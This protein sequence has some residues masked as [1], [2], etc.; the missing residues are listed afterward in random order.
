VEHRPR[1]EPAAR[2]RGTTGNSGIIWE[3]A[4]TISFRDPYHQIGSAGWGCRG[5]LAMGAH[6]FCI[7]SR[8]V[9]GMAFNQ[10]T[11]GDVVTADGWQ[12]CGFYED[13]KSFAQVLTHEIGHT[14]GFDHS[15]DAS[16]IMYAT[17]H[18]DGRCAALAGS[19]K[20]GVVFAYPAGGLGAP[21]TFTISVVRAGSG[22]G[23]VTSTPA[24]ITCGTDCSQAYE[25]GT[26]VTLKATVPAGSRFAG[27]SGGCTSAATTCTV[28]LS[29]NLSVTA[30][31]TAMSP[32][33]LVVTAIAD[34]PPTAATPGGRF[35]VHDTVS[36]AGE[37]TA[38]TSRVSYFL[39]T[40]GSATGGMALTGTRSVPSLVSGR[41]SS[42]S[43]TVTIPASTPS[44]TYVLVG[45]ADTANST[46]ETAEGN[47]CHASAG[48]I[49]I[50]R[51]DLHVATLSAPPPS[52]ARGKKFGVTDTTRNEGLV[53]APATVTRYYLSTSSTWSASALALTG[54][55]S[56]PTL[57]PG[58]GSTGSLQV[59]VPA[60]TPPG[61]Y[62]LIACADG[63]NRLTETSKANNCLAASAR[64]AVAP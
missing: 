25:V 7:G 29:A 37:V 53:P 5:I 49:A 34:P 33:D 47:N 9:S 19:D 16:A 45:C 17:V 32:A 50:A 54:S 36:N 40:T 48:H 46:P 64:L 26:P 27:W 43:A 21:S 52:A 22:T 13:Y 42:G 56:V 35:G 62:Y 57:G 1:V 10:I 23:T 41:Q 24:G 31:F 12:G 63:A 28:T 15:R 8:V 30:T 11:E 14:V 6:F 59:T 58:A 51:P 4:N 20:A 2:E 3:G 44:G 55:R 18:F 61:T 38:L 60:A 39:S